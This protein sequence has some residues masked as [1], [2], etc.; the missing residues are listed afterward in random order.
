MTNAEEL[1]ACT[2]QKVSNLHGLLFAARM[3]VRRLCSALANGS[4]PYQV[5][6]LFWPRRLIAAC[7]LQLKV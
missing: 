3:L 7:S 1:T 2:E 5:D 6:T 4:S